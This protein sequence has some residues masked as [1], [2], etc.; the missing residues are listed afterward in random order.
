MYHQHKPTL[1]DTM[2]DWLLSKEKNNVLIIWHILTWIL[3][4]RWHSLQD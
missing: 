1:T 3:V 2:T 4:Y